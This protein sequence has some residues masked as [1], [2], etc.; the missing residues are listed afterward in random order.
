MLFMKVNFVMEIPFF[1]VRLLKSCVSNH[2]TTSKVTRMIDRD[3][4]TVFYSD[5]VSKLILFL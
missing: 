5:N 4:L 2:I 3:L 1:L